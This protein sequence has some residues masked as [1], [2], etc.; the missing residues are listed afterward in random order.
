MTDDQIVDLARRHS[1]GEPAAD[2]EVRAMAERAFAG[3]DLAGLDFLRY[4]IE[5][6][7]WAGPEEVLPWKRKAE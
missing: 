4:G 3:D 5:R 7:K 1:Q 6:G 2:A